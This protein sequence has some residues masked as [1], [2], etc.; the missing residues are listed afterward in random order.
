MHRATLQLLLLLGLPPQ[1]AHGQPPPASASF[2][3]PRQS[4]AGGGGR[5]SSAS[6]QL[7]ASIGQVLAGPPQGSASFSLNA[8]FRR[9][10]EPLA[11]LPESVFRNG[12]ETP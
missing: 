9:I 2:E 10:S 1:P 3:L 5:A 6:F 12:F 4:I 11:P 8:G 7:E